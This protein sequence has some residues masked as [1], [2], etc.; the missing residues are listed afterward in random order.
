MSKPLTPLMTVDNNLSQGVQ[1]LNCTLPSHIATQKVD[2]VDVLIR[3]AGKVCHVCCPQSELGDQYVLHNLLIRLA[4]SGFSRRSQFVTNEHSTY[5][6]TNENKRCPQLPKHTS[7]PGHIPNSPLRADSSRHPY[8]LQIAARYSPDRELA[9][10]CVV[11]KYDQEMLRVSYEVDED[12][13]NKQWQARL[14]G[15]WDRGT[16]H[17]HHYIPFAVVIA[18]F[19]VLVLEL[20]V[21]VSEKDFVIAA[22]TMFIAAAS[23][24][25]AGVARALP[26]FIAFCWLYSFVVRSNP[27]NQW[28]R[29]TITALAIYIAWLSWT[30]FSNQLRMLSERPCVGRKY[31]LREIGS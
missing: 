9:A 23:V 3:P 30:I 1:S 28:V 7:L 8:A 31:R 27:E 24:V 16:R 4:R 18:P 15:T 5:D 22:T 17:W 25:P 21:V 14:A 13:W 11:T 12:M 19:V 26:T 10:N 29:A 6:A 2:A 20:P